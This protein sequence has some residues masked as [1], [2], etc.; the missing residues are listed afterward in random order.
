M[1]IALKPHTAIGRWSVLFGGLLLIELVVTVAVGA[2]YAPAQGM[3]GFLL[4]HLFG[5]GTTA[6]LALVLGV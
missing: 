5:W 6:A 2:V 1:A 3:A 4:S